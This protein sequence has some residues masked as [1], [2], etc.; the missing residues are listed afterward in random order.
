MTSRSPDDRR[1]QRRSPLVLLAAVTLLT[2]IGAGVAGML[3]ALLLHAVQ[4]LA[5]GYSL[6][7]LIGDE[8]FLQGVM[9]TTP[10]RRLLVMLACGLVAG[11]GW[12]ATYR[13]GRPLVSISKAVSSSDPR[14]P[15][16]STLSHAL[17]QIV[18]VALG[19]PLGREVAP[20][21][22]GAAF[23]GW[24]AHRVGLSVSES[25]I[26][27]ACGAGAGLAAVYNVPL[28][29]A[30][31]VLE[32][33]LGTFGWAALVPAV[34]TSVIATLVARIGLGDSSQYIIP[35]FDSH[36]ALVIWAVVCG[37]IFGMAAYVFTQIMSAAKAKAPTNGMLPV[38]SVIN[39]LLI[40]CLALYFP[41]LLGNG[42]TPAAMSFDNHLTIELAAVLLA[43]RVVITAS[44]LR[45]GAQGGLLTPALANGALLAVVLGGV[46]NH[47]WP[48]ATPAGA[49]AVIG[50]AAFLAASMKMPITAT[51]LI[52]EFTGV[53]QEFLIPILAAVAGSVAA[54]SFCDR[55]KVAQVMQRRASPITQLTGSTN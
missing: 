52:F 10:S 2:G 54:F 32:V 55:L 51:V 4:H 48:A 33:L 17:L 7:Q 8:S 41:Q 42:K 11:L 23:A 14:M 46:W 28:G 43:L 27:V 30:V 16:G 21:E 36:T 53:N 22:M 5:Y 45:A 3:L 50:A 35:A 1:P 40:G 20:R 37:P 15:M 24:L 38:L 34:A 44:S 31:F 9:A 19:S 12:W 39:F 49:F 13:I 26:M 25:Q 6:H 47:F 29:G 18:T